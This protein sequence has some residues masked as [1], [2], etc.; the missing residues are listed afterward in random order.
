MPRFVG[1]DQFGDDVELWDFMGRDAP[2][3]VQVSALWSPPDL[4]WAEWLSG[5]PDAFGY[6]P[7]VPAAIA[8]GDLNYVVILHENAAGSP[9]SCPDDC[10]SMASR[11]GPTPTAVLGDPDQLLAPFIRLAYYPSYILV[12]PDGTISWLE[13]ESGMFTVLWDLLEIRF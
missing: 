3:L 13:G 11:L 4:G 1:V 6:G 5:G 12:E 2:V 9:P 7:T 10:L 8:A